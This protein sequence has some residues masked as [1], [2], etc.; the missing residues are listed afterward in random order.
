M[1]ANSLRVLIGLY[2]RLKSNISKLLSFLSE[3]AG[4][5]LERF[6]N[7]LH[8]V[9]GAKRTIQEGVVPRR[10]N[11]VLP[12]AERF[13]IETT[14][15]YRSIGQQGWYQGKTMNISGSG[16]LFRGKNLIA[17]KTRV[18]MIFALPIGGSRASGANVTCFGQIV[19][20]VPRV[21]PK[22]ETGLAATIEEYVLAHAEEVSAA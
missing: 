9:A 6:R 4:L 5:A 12:R 22:G 11:R 21:G 7:Q 15:R 19:R 18:E 1:K 20:K 3:E 10:Q 16:V 14:I 13:A 8:L 17:P 2:P